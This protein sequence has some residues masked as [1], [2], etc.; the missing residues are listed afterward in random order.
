MGFVLEVNVTGLCLFVAEPDRMHVLMPDTRPGGGAHHPG[1]DTHEAVVKYDRVY[2]G[3]APGIEPK[4]I[5]DLGI[6]LTPTGHQPGAAPLPTQVVDLFHVVMKHIPRTHLGP[7]PTKPDVVEP[8]TLLTRI[9][10]PGSFQ[11]SPVLGARW[12]LGALTDVE[13]TPRV[14]WRTMVTDDHLTWTQRP[15]RSPHTTPVER[16]RLRPPPGQPLVLTFAHVPPN[17][18]HDVPHAP[19]EAVHFRALYDLFPLQGQGPVPQ[20]FRHRPGDH[21]GHPLPEFQPLAVIAGVL[22]G[23]PYTCMVAQAPLE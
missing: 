8:G 19:F 5:G 6:D 4:P 3:G 14:T 17:E 22:G 9:T 13:M 18:G 21:P 23:S 12:N 15:L 16:P 1:I 11:A 10:L 7:T 20:L 2:E